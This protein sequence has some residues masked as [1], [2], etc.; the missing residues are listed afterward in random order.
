VPYKALDE[1]IDAL[2]KHLL[3]L[4]R[5]EAALLM[6]RDAAAL[7][8][9]FP[10]LDRVPVIAES[11]RRAADLRDPFQVRSRAFGALREMLGRLGDR[12]PVV[13]FLDDIQW[14]DADSAGLI[15]EL[16]APPDPPP[17]L[18][19]LCF[20]AEEAPTSALLNELKRRLE[21]VGLGGREHR[22]N[23]GNL[24][25]D[26]ALSLARRLLGDDDHERAAVIARESAG[27]PFFL[28]ELAQYARTEEGQRDTGE[29]RLDDV[30]QRRVSQLPPAARTALRVVSIAGNSLD[31]RVVLRAG[32]FD[33]EPL[34]SALQ[35]LRLAN[36][37]KLRGARGERVEPFHDKIREAVVDSLRP[38]EKTA[39]HR[40]LAHAL[41]AT[42]ADPETLLVHF[43]AG[44]EIE[45]TRQLVRVAAE[46]STSALAFDRA[47]ELWQEALALGGWDEQERRTLGL[48]RAEALARAGRG[49]RAAAAYLSLAED[50]PPMEALE[51]R[52]RAG[53]ELLLAGEIAAGTE[54]TRQVLA[55]VD[56]AP[57]PGTIRL[58]LGLLVTT[59]RV[60]LLGRRQPPREPPRLTTRE[61]V[62]LDVCA[63]CAKAFTIVEVLLGLYFSQLVALYALQSRSTYHLALARIGRAGHIALAGTHRLD[64]AL[65]MMDQAVELAASDPRADE[66]RRIA[67]LGAGV[68][69]SLLGHLKASTVKLDEVMS[70]TQHTGGA[71]QWD[72]DTAMYVS[73]LSWARLGQFNEVASRLSRYLR[74]AVNRGDLY[75]STMLRVGDGSI[76]WMV[77]DTPDEG[78]A[79]V[80][81]ALS[82]W[83]RPSFDTA[84]WL[85]QCS[86]AALDQYR[87]RHEQALARTRSLIETLRWSRIRAVRTMWSLTHLHATRSA[88][89]CLA[90]APD[91]PGRGR[92]AASLLRQARRFAPVFHLPLWHLFRAGHAWLC[93]QREESLAAL[94]EGHAAATRLEMVHYRAFCRLRR[95]QLIGGDEGTAL[96][97]EGVAWMRSEGVVN[98]SRFLQS[99]SPGFPALDAVSQPRDPGGS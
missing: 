26:Q 9:I 4:P 74:D 25:L 18:F 57:P 85:G 54:V 16:V 47:A 6:P 64:E 56:L 67:A 90:D 81:H 93:G 51:L 46:R 38:E 12:R 5:E 70:S 87:G 45:R 68:T 50:Q 92:L 49:T 96:I 7:A 39:L 66:V 29:L 76:L 28:G 36:L 19:I 1:V 48:A 59:L 8:R 37:I 2:S 22:L 69:L 41:D 60:E 71:T 65:T 44:G 77:R 34:A 17:A 23:L 58:I 89:A 80:E 63:S 72:L 14:G 27:S 20:R 32:A 42:D 13:I 43:R 79:D 84:G 82:Q 91:D 94:A 75:L 61:Q 52:R 33:E 86:L 3:G 24:S 30:I 97:T 21:V 78:Q 31:R 40:D 53:E 55:A 10:V 15:A 11:P 83:A 88:V 73:M 98:P 62:R 35:T 95:G 99:H